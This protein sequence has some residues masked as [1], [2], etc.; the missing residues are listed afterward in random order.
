MTYLLQYQQPGIN[1]IIS[2]IR[3]TWNHQGSSTVGFNSYLKTGHL[4]PGCMYGIVGNTY[5]ASDF[6]QSF[7]LSIPSE[8]S[9]AYLWERFIEVVNGYSFAKGIENSFLLI[10]SFITRDRPQFFV[11]D[12]EQ[13][14][15]K[16]AQKE[17]TNIVETF[18]SGKSKLDDYVFTHVNT[19]LDAMQMYLEKQEGFSKELINK[20]S[21]FFICQQINEL[22]LTSERMVL[23]KDQVGGPFH[24]I[25]QTVD[26]Q[27]FQ[28]P[29]VYILSFPNKEN[30]TI[31]SEMYRVAFPNNMMYIEKNSSFQIG[32]VDGD[33]G[34]G[35]NFLINQASNPDF[36]GLEVE[37][38]ID[39]GRKGLIGMDYWSFL[40]I[41]RS[42]PEN[43]EHFV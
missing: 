5:L 24:F 28:A 21:P 29:S 11:L 35:E 18:G 33:L 16:I 1:A 26:T 10:L 9:L 12:S 2:D 38:I 37:E 13:G 3:V 32:K 43:R 19:K 23:E 39:I 30:R 15:I 36:I 27:K 34:V 25:Y 22:I 41:G 7:K 40:G 8:E 14:S 17:G 42:N 20:I 31:H 6:I 4:Y